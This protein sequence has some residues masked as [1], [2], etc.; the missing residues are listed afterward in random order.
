MQVTWV[1]AFGLLGLLAAAALLFVFDPMQVDYFPRCP[2]LALT[3]FQCAGCGSQRALHA[4]SHLH[5]LEAWSFNPLL[6]LSLP[7]ALVGWFAEWG[8]H[9]SSAWARFR[10]TVY[11]RS[12]SYVVLCIIVLFTVG[13]NL[14]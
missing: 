6:I 3:G 12:A 8:A 13:R 1:S 5:F 11:G 14:L 2:V 7:Y 10:K 9:R 4:L